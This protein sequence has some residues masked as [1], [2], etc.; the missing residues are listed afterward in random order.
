MTHHH[1]NIEVI[2][3][4]AEDFLVFASKINNAGK[5]GKNVTEYMA[6]IKS[7]YKLIECAE[8]ILT[9]RDGLVLKY[10]ENQQTIHDLCLQVD[11]LQAEI[12]KFSDIDN[13]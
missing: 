10:R 5:A 11:Q 3:N 13:F 7:M 12:K 2:N 9:E 1:S 4:A 6:L 8:R